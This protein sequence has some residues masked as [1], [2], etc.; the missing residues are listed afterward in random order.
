[1]CLRF[2]N[3]ALKAQNYQ[4]PITKKVKPFAQMCK[5]YC[6]T[7]KCAL[8]GLLRCRKRKIIK[9]LNDHAK[10]YRAPPKH[11]LGWLVG[12]SKRKITKILISKKVK[13]FSWACKNILDTLKGALPN[14]ALKAQN[15][16]NTLFTK[17]CSF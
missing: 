4:N 2:A 14:R 11:A 12:R 10:T 1:M 16:K 3:R 15:Y 13:A 17:S 5:K 7:P 9:I 8:D 6:D